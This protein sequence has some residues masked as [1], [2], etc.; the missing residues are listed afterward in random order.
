MAVRASSGRPSLDNTT[1]KKANVMGCGFGLRRALHLLESLFIALKTEQHE[2]LAIIGP[3]AVAV[4]QAAI[5]QIG[6]IGSGDGYL[7]PVPMADPRATNIDGGPMSVALQQFRGQAQNF[8]AGFETL[9]WPM[10]WPSIG[11]LG[12]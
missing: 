11:L 10:T 4:E 9:T 5:D 12:K 8:V 3:A 6:D 1:A 7:A 2:G